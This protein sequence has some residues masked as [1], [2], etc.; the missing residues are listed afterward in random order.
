LFN[1]LQERFES[2]EET[3]RF[4]ETNLISHVENNDAVW[5][6]LHKIQVG[7]HS[8]QWSPQKTY[9]RPPAYL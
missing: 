5:Y 8:P 6:N 2:S 9:S 7:W 3:L 4:P 1:H